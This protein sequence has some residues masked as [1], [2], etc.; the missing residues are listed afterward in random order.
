MADLLTIILGGVLLL[1]GGA[2]VGLIFLLMPST[3]P[4]PSA[5]IG[6][7]PFEKDA[8]NKDRD[9]YDVVIVGAGPAGSTC[10]YYLSK[11]GAK[12]LLLEKQKF[13]R[14]KHCGNACSLFPMLS[15]PLSMIRIES[16]Y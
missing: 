16:I 10:A 12:V 1:V 7:G 8:K 2:A 3:P 11:Q 5:T 13:P 9:Y 15:T 4:S 14:D 6:K